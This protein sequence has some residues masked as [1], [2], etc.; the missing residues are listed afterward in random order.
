MSLRGI[1][2]GSLVPHPRIAG[3]RL[4]GAASAALFLLLA[5]SAWA[6][7]TGGASGGT[8]S[9]GSGDSGFGLGGNNKDKPIEISAENGIEWNRDARTYIARGNALAQQGDTSIAADTLIAY[10]DAQ[11]ELSRW[12]ADGNVKI[13][14]SKSTS[15]GDHAD[16]EESS[17]LLVL[18]G[19]NLKVVTDKQTVT[20]RDQIEYWRDKDI[21]VAKGNVVIVRPEKNTTIHSDVATAYFRD[22]VDDPA[23]PQ[24]ESADGSEVYQVKADGHV[25]VDRTEK[26]QTGFSDHLVY[27][28][29]TEV[30]VLTGNVVIHSKDNT[31]KG[32]RAEL[33]LKNDV[34]RLLPAQGQRVF[35]VIKPKDKNSDNTTDTGAQPAPVTQ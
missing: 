34:S 10:L 33:D 24:D 16:Y 9:G 18:T 11:D 14:T 29:N 30:A 21:V 20:A 23:T 22:K 27:D 4:L 7:D 8:N 32:G 26:Q 19:R 35:T 17:R 3:A 2:K 5:A 12:E 13:Q 28:P 31:Y 15:Y 6:Q 1:I 25:R